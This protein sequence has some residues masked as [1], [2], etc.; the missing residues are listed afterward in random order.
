[1]KKRWWFLIIFLF[2]IIFFIIIASLGGDEKKKNNQNP[3]EDNWDTVRA[4]D[5]AV[6]A[7]GWG[8]P[9]LLEVN[10]P[11]IEDSTFISLDGN[12]LYL[13]HYEG[14]TTTKPEAHEVATYKSEK[15]FKTKSV[16]VSSLNSYVGLM[17]TASGD[18]FYS[19]PSQGLENGKFD[20]DI[21]K[22][23]ELLVFNTDEDWTNPHYCV[24]KDEL[25]FDSIRDKEISVL[26]NAAANNFDGVPELA[27]S[28][29]NDGGSNFQAHLT[30][31][32]EKL[33][34]TSE[35]GPGHI[36]IVISERQSDDSWSSPEVVIHSKIG[37]GE[38]TLTADEQYLY[39]VQVF[40]NNEGVS[41]IDVLYTK[42]K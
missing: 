10:T 18:K 29:I 6:V 42:S 34:F 36:S 14:D 4:N 11:N 15:P 17:I 27:P 32:C 2:L 30:P 23:E 26:K 9:V 35:R 40:Q 7:N 24:A 8:T 16:I 25:W 12:T 22:N 41:Q 19:N 31:D 39:F 21:Y 20:D 33:Y 38:P 1:M 3:L 5:V 28:P 37:V 13:F